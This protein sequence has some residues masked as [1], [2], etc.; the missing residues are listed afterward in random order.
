M[1]NQIDNTSNPT[2]QPPP[3]GIGEGEQKSLPDAS[4]R[5]L[6]M[7]RYDYAHTVTDRAIYDTIKERARTMRKNPTPA[8]E[9][10]WS[11]LRRKQVRRIAVSSPSTDRTVHC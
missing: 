5:D 11:K 1:T 8:E 3:Q 9:R 6:G 10:L 4:G 2:A 7:G